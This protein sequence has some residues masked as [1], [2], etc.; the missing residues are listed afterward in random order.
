MTNQQSEKFA[1][2]SDREKEIALEILKE[3]SETGKSESYDEL[4]Y[5]DYNEIPVD[6]E[7]FLK[8]RRYLGNGLTNE[9]GKFT[10]FPYWVETLK[11]VFPTNI[12]TAYNTLILTG[13]IGLGK[14]LIGVICVLYAMYR[15]LCLKDPYVYYGL[16]RIDHITFSFINI[17]LDAARGVAWAK[18]QELLK[19]SPWF[20]EHGTL[21][22]S[23]DPQWQPNGGIELVAGSQPRH[24]LGRAVFGSFEDEISFQLN[25]DVEKQK[26]KAKTLV[27]TVDARMQSRFMK[28]EKLPTVH[29]IA[30]SKR[31]EQSFL[32]TYIEMKRKNESKTTLIVDEPQWIIRNDKSSDRFFYVAVGNKFLDSEVLPLSVTEQELQIYRDKG[33]RLLEVPFG[34]REQFVDDI[35]IALTDIAGISTTNSTS[36]ISGVRWAKCRKDGVENP[37]SKEVLVVG[38]SPDDK[39]Q[40]Y[41]F[42]DM[43]KVPKEL[44]YKPLYVHLD[45]SLSGDKTG[46]SGVFIRGKKPHEEGQ[47]ESKELYYQLAFS[48]AIKAPKGYQ[49]SFEKNRQFIYW[50]KDQGF[51]LKGVSS[52][53]FQSADL[54]QQLISHRI[55]F[56][57]IS[58]D[59]LQD[60][61]CK[62][63]LV[64]KNAIYEERLVVY[65][66]KLLTDE[67]IGL[68]RDGNGKID[69][70][71]SGINSKDTADAVCG[72]L[73][74][75]S[76]HAEEYAFDFGE[77]LD[78]IS[79][80]NCDLDGEGAK[81]QFIV[82]MAEELKNFH[83]FNQPRLQQQTQQ[84]NG[85]GLDFGMGR[86]VPYNGAV[87]SDG[88]LIW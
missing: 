54:G 5:A 70:S 45:M 2:L 49:V 80:A 58:V 73:Y 9:D 51:N 38:N 87:A 52:D 8:D 1:Q 26:Q 79:K 31:T 60:R 85:F 40:Y 86:A 68:V 25:Q 47:L 4:I 36:Y 10:V 23:N 77:D 59:R 67:I 32:E 12:D 28:G 30:S 48:V 43:S 16:Q 22:K 72:A 62:P 55:P 11:K 64:F 21:S 27:S 75:A 56:D 69:H 50:L 78:T 81:E 57:I 41:D 7:T 3:F 42:F 61:V 46:I 24:I 74:N 15:M 82:D 37:F 76:Q 83:L 65:N 44:M 34:Y 13:G 19:L 66:T 71:P 17:T 18:C 63:Y 53:T 35:D 88:M 84:Q 20:L 29:I 6:I 39:T 33:F 14:S